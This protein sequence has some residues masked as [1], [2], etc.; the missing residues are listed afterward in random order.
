[1]RRKTSGIVTSLS[2]DSVEMNPESSR[3]VLVYVCVYEEYRSPR[4][5]LRDRAQ[6]S[7]LVVPTHRNYDPQRNEGEKMRRVMRRTEKERKREENVER[8]KRKEKEEK[9]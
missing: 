3:I 1:M 5:W 4:A 9:G 7:T 6:V 2:L 8:E